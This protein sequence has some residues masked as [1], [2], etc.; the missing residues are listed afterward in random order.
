MYV[1]ELRPAWNRTEYLRLY[2]S[3]RKYVTRLH[4][5]TA[6][7]FTFSAEAEAVIAKLVNPLYRPRVVEC[8]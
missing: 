3:G 1:I 5:S 4:T 6:T 2:K 7:K 8:T